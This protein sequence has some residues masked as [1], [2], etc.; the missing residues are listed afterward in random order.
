[1]DYQQALYRG[2]AVFQRIG[3]EKTFGHATGNPHLDQP[4]NYHFIFKHYDE[5]LFPI[6]DEIRAR[7]DAYMEDIAL[8]GAQLAIEKPIDGRGDFEPD[9]DFTPQKENPRTKTESHIIRLA[10]IWQ[11]KHRDA[12][13]E[14][15]RASSV[16]LAAAIADRRDRYA[17]L[18]K[19]RSKNPPLV[20]PVAQ[21]I[22]N[23]DLRLMFYAGQTWYGFAFNDQGQP[24]ELI[25][26]H[27]LPLRDH[28]TRTS[29]FSVNIRGEALTGND[30]SPQTYSRHGYLGIT[31]SNYK[32]VDKLSRDATIKQ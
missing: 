3:Y 6:T 26:P 7:V 18:G 32:V 20:T 30:G 11:N 19:L 12:Y 29:R 14:D 9:F 15:D 25:F 23:Y 4:G 5:D 17:T 8:E 13:P 24:V 31:L 28:A 21:M 22:G 10:Q 2:E 27:I 1:M 16:G